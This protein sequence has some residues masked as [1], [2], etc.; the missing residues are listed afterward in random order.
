MA[1]PSPVQER[2]TKPE[3][4]ALCDRL[5]A[6][7]PDALRVCIE[8]FIVESRGRWHNR[9]RAMMA[10]RFKHSALT[11]DQRRRLCGAVAERL[12]TG[13]FTEQFRDQLRLLR[14][15]DPDAAC[16][17]AQQCLASPVPHVRR[18]ATWLEAHR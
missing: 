4:H 16:R 3:L 6:G 1:P 5:E 13:R 14:H 17:V 9:A 7:D 8:F 2:F 10:R 18:H 11:P 12:R 15:L